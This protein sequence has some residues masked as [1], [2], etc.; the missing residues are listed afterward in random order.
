MK[1][2]QGVHITVCL[3]ARYVVWVSVCVC[4]GVYA[5]VARVVSLIPTWVLLNIV[6]LS[7]SLYPHCSSVRI[8][9]D[10]ALAAG[11]RTPV[12]STVAA[13][14]L[15][16]ILC[17]RM[18]MTVHAPMSAHYTFHTEGECP[19]GLDPPPLLPKYSNVLS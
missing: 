18:Y 15:P 2:T 12:S 13:P 19:G 14:N 16:L 9:W 8:G 10:L 3:L 5:C 11:G 6:T 4:V 1:L 7:K 17:V